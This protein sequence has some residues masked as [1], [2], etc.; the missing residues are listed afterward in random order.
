MLRSALHEVRLRD[1][2]HALRLVAPEQLV[3]AALLTAASYLALTI[4]DFIALRVID[5]PLPWR[6]A[7][8]AS[9][10]GYA[11]S[12]SLGL[13]LLTGGSARY[14][15]YAAAGLEAGDVARVMLLA[16]AILSGVLLGSVLCRP[17]TRGA[18]TLGWNF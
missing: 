8:L 11:I 3:G 17:H 1:V 14:R 13:S 4:Y 15:V 10:T 7:A 16:S 9:F 6:T 5:R 2:R 12:N 18:G